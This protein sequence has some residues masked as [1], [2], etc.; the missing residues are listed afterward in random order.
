MGFSTQPACVH[1]STTQLFCTSPKCKNGS[2]SSCFL[3]QTFYGLKFR[4]LVVFHSG[5]LWLLVGL[6]SSSPSLLAAKGFS[7]NDAIFKPG[8]LSGSIQQIPA[9]LSG[10]ANTSFSEKYKLVAVISKNNQV[11]KLGKFRC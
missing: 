2:M 5:F 4:L 3:T 11:T 7:L 9:Y 6:T 1:Y 10:R 8:L